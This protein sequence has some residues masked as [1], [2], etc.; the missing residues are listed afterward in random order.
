[1]KLSIIIP[2]Y[3]RHNDLK[4]CLLALKDQELSPHEIL[5]IY[6]QEDVDTQDVIRGHIGG[7]PIRPLLV[8]VSGVVAALNRGL[9]AVT[10][11]LVAMTDDDAAPRTDWVRRIIGHFTSDPDLTGLGGRDQVFMNGAILEGA[12][13]KV[14][15]VSF[16]GRCTGNH[17]LGV[18]PVREVDIL[19]GV[20][21][22]YRVSHLEGLRFDARLAG[23]GAQV[24][25]ELA[26]ALA[27]RKRG[28]RLIYDPD[29]VV[30]HYPSVRHDEDKRNSF[31]S[32]ARQNEAHNQTLALMDYLPCP[33]QQLFVCWPLGV[34]TRAMPGVAAYLMGLAGERTGRGRALFLA[35]LKGRL[36]G[37]RTWRHST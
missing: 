36:E 31:S 26:F 21:M 16:Y 22:S 9:D 5:V 35:T 11:D 23:T 19:K 28:R 13:P 27:L 6:R 14:G 12:C 34:G 20:N 1:M 10:G 7:L 24:D 32:V 3:K 2:T 25:N 18:G 17:H 4:R 33:R 37:I 30:D 8:E 29:L 15:L